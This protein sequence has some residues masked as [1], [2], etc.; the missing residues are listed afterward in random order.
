MSFSGGEVG[1]GG[2]TRIRG[3]ASLSLGAQPLI[4]VDGVRVN[5]DESSGVFGSTGFRG[6]SQPSRLGDF[7]P[8]EIENIEIIKGPAAATLYGT[9]ASNGVIQIFTK[10]GRTG[11]AE[12][13]PH[14]EAGRELLSGRLQHV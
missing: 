11:G 2:T 7:N 6:N 5:G 10:R 9:E 8:D 14:R 12:N 3:I 1:T 4:Y 13:Q